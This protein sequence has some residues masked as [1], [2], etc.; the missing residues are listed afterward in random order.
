MITDEIKIPEEFA[1]VCP[2]SDSEFSAQMARL[3]EEPMFKSVAEYAMPGVDYNILKSKLLSL[4]TKDEFQIE[5]MKPFLEML[6][7][8]TN[9]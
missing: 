2:F 5:I 6:V 4:K 3:V 9:I 7:R 1:D 8:N